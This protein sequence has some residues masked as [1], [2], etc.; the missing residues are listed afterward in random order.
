MECGSVFEDLLLALV[1]VDSVIGG[2]RPFQP[3]SFALPFLE[4]RSLF[5][6]PDLLFGRPALLLIVLVVGQ[7]LPLEDGGRLQRLHPVGIVQCQSG[8]HQEAVVDLVHEY[9]QGKLDQ[10]DLSPVEGSQLSSKGAQRGKSGGQVVGRG[11]REGIDLKGDEVRDCH[12][13]HDCRHAVD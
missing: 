3:H 11:V 4:L 8:Q 12:L 6:F 1:P 5:Q 13:G 10:F 2:R 9:P 7:H